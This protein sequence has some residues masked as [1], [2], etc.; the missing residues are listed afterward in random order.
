[1][2]A[3]L[4]STASRQAARAAVARVA[5]VSASRSISMAATRPAFKLSAPA[6]A[7]TIKTISFNGKEDEIVHER[8]DWPQEKLLDYFKNDTIALI[9]YGSQGYG[10]GLNMRD[11]GLNVIIGVRKDGASWKA[12]QEDGWVPG[13]NLFDVNEAI[14]KGTIIMNLLSDAAQSETWPQIKPLITK[15]KTLY[16][17]HGFSPVFKDLTKVETPADVDVILVAPKGSGRTVRSLFKEGRGINSSYAVWNDVTGKADEKAVAL[18]IAVGS[19]Y[20]YQTTFEKEVRSDLYGERGCLMGGIHGMFLAQYEVLRER[21]HSPS[22]AFNETVEEAT[23]SLYPLIGKYGMDYMYDACSTTAR[24]GA[25]DWSPKFKDALKPVFNELY[26]RVEDGSETQRSLEFNSQKD[27]RA[28][29][30][31]E[32]QDIRDLEIWRVGKEVRKLRPEN[33]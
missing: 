14:G 5:T 7:R 12:A 33:N 32:L 17:S 25:L 2:S 27:Y 26:D 31:A 1:M 6:V 19:G 18:A 16:F 23:Q 24:R 3:R 13:K 20:V 9:G 21:G 10:Q 4:F 29:F 22:E 30:E 11:N 8:A 15:G 28:K